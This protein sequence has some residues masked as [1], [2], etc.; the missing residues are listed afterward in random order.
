MGIEPPRLAT[1][2]VYRDRRGPPTV[3]LVC[4]HLVPGAQGAD[5][6]YREDRPLL[7]A[8]HRRE[9]RRLGR[10]VDG[11]RRLGQVVYVVG[12]ANVDRLCLPGL[13]SAWDGRGQQPGT[14][15]PPSPDRRRLRSHAAGPG[16]SR[17]EG[18]RPP[19]GGGHVGGHG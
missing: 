10:L 7:A 5:D 13:V 11:Q 1:L 19:G 4:H 2:G 8:R 15:R 9:V 17:G 16:P 3:S 12:D 14:F 6:R 18:L